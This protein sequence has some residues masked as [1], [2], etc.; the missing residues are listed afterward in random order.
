MCSLTR[1]T[2][3]RVKYFT[4][5]AVVVF[6][7]DWGDRSVC[8]QWSG[9]VTGSDL[10]AANK[11]IQSDS[12]FDDLRYM[13]FLMDEIDHLDVSIEDIETVA[14]M[15][16]GAAKSNANLRCA[17]VAS[18]DDWFGLSAF[19]QMHMD[20]SDGPT[21]ALKLFRDRSSAEDWLYDECMI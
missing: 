5:G 20:E 4:S 3:S 8:C 21:W 17:S 11:Q 2:Y 14:A 9:T 19:Y 18:N 6:S 15:G 1:N 10:V 16:I 12:R 13:L 7:L